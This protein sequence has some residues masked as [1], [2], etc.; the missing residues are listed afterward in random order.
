[1]GRIP[2]GHW[3]VHRC[4]NKACCNPAHLTTLNVT[5]SLE[6][7][8]LS[9]IVKRDNSDCWEFQGVIKA[10]YGQ[11]T[12]P[13]GRHHAAH[14]VAYTLWVEPIP[15]GLQIQH[16]CGNS[17]CVNPTHLV[18]GTAQENAALRAQYREGG[19]GAGQIAGYD[20]Q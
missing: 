14:R 7:R 3:V 18:A 2:K 20:T 11:I 8:L 10:G 1:V 12:E 13:S 17:L 19:H 4:S 9:K 5:A 15:K 6:Q 16:L